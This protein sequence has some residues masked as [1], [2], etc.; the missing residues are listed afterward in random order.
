M[1]S[2]PWHS[3]MVFKCVSPIPPTGSQQVTA[4]VKEVVQGWRY[5][6]ID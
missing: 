1:N 5:L 2:I 3:A 4:L 6:F